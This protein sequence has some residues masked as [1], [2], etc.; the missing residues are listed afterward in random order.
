[1]PRCNPMQYISARSAFWIFAASAL[2]HYAFADDLLQVVPSS[3]I[4][5][6]GR[7]QH[8]LVFAAQDVKLSG[9]KILWVTDKATGLAAAP[10]TVSLRA[11]A[12][13][14]AAGGFCELTIQA[15]S[16]PRP[17]SSLSGEFGIV[18]ETVSVD[19]KQ[20]AGRRLLRQAFTVLGE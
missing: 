9:T 8:L 2:S 7:P 14:I 11:G 19:G 18:Y 3:V 13:T 16:G 20:P 5:S 6:A 1:R 10:S 15:G 4:V 17:S 12:M